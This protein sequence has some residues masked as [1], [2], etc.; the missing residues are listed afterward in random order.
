METLGKACWRILKTVFPTSKLSYYHH[1]RYIHTK[2][3]I[4]KYGCVVKYCSNE[5]ES[6]NAW[7]IQFQ[8]RKSS[9]NGSVGR[10]FVETNILEQMLY[11]DLRKVNMAAT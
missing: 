9:H 11:N 8:D 7:G 2:E 1:I 4:E 10:T 6:K 3:L 5:T